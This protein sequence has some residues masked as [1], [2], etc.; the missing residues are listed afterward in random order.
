MRSLLFASLAVAALPLFAQEKLAETIEVR[1]VNVDVVVNDRAGRPV[2]GLTKDD[3]EIYENGK[4]QP[5]SNFYEITP[6]ASLPL[7]VTNGAAAPAAAASPA[8]APAP[9]PSDMRVRRFVVVLDNYSLEPMQ[10]N[11]VLAALRKFIN[12]SMQPTDEMAVYLWARQIQVLTPLTNDKAAIL[13]ILD[14]AATRSR[15]GM[16]AGQEDERARE[17]CRQFI[18]DVDEKDPDS[19][20]PP[21]AHDPGGSGGGL[22][23][24]TYTWENAYIDCQGGITT[25][26]DAQWAAS[27]SLLLDMKTMVSTL[28]GIDGRKVFVLAGASLPEHPGRQA[29]MWLYNEFQPYQKFIK[30][31]QLNPTKAFGQ[32]NARSQT[33]SIDDVAHFANANGVTF[34]MIDAADT[35][36]NSNAERRGITDERTETNTENFLQFAD[37]ASAYHNLAA[38]TGGAALS[39]TQNFDAAFQ[40]LDRDLTSFY[41]LGY[42][43]SSDATGERSLTVK[44]KKSGMY[45][46]ARKSFLPK[47]ADDEMNDR[48]VANVS[49]H[50]AAGEWPVRLSA[51]TPEKNGDLFKLPVTI[52]MDP[53]LTLLP[54]DSK[55]VGGF[56]LYIVVGTKDGSRS[57]V[58]KTARKIEV[59]PAAEADFRGKPMK[60]TLMLSVRPGDNIVSVGVVDQI[61]NATGFGRVDVV[62]Q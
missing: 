8:S 7:T 27:R 11:G 62:A 4:L 23:P 45:A 54:Q 44:V 6:S 49:H 60:Y 22:K 46:R 10:R 3:F 32:G 14:S 61:S 48:V 43:P 30:K 41:S 31:Q 5:I 21:G 59:P 25:F 19:P 58:T 47:S 39:N 52:E 1:V 20:Q 53:K 57:K 33:L 40:T 15:V 28:A 13:R 29:L 50:G 55:M 37:T 9:A 56:V 34:Y 24:L 12:T 18:K 36:D 17:Q 26:A 38:I 2:Q 16:T 35:R 51:Q 42:R